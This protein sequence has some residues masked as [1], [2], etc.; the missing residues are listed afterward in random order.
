MPQIRDVSWKDIAELVAL[1]QELLAEMES[2]A[3]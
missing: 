1:A 3:N 2:E